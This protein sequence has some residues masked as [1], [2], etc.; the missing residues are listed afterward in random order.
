M[1]RCAFGAVDLLIGLLIL[2]IVCIFS[3]KTFQNVSA[4]GNKSDIKNIKQQVNE[5]VSE[6]ERIKKESEQIQ[7]EFLNNQNY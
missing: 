2:G 7:R 1:R 4:V 5:Q 6:I 3:M